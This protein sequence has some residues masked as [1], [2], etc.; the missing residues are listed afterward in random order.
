MAT[1]VCYQSNP[2]SGA[3]SV[4]TTQTVEGIKGLSN[5]FV[6]VISN[7]TTY[8]VSSTHEITIISCGSV[9]MEN[10][11]AVKNPLGLRCQTVFDFA[12]NIA[13]HF[14]PDGSFRTSKLEG[15]D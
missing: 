8:Y 12:N 5:C 2:C 3:P 13:I 7:N 6:Y 15:G 9:F 11:D 10:Y 1:N 14:A 4:V